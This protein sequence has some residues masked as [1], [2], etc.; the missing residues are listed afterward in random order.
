MQIRVFVLI[1]AAGAAAMGAASG[2]P[3]PGFVTVIGRAVPGF[4]HSDHG[5][6]AQ[7]QALALK[8]SEA[9]LGYC[10][11]PREAAI[12]VLLASGREIAGY[13]HAEEKEL[14]YYYRKGVRLFIVG[15]EPD[16]E[17]EAYGKTLQRIA[18]YARSSAPEARLIGG[19]CFTHGPYETLYQKCG[20]RESCHMV[21]FHCYSD[22]PDTGINIGAVGVLREIMKKYGDA[23]KLVFLGEGWGP[24][25]ELRTVPRVSPYIPPSVSEITLMRQFL[26]NGWNNICTPRENYNPNWVYGVLFFTLSDNWGFDYSHFYNGGL[27][28]FWGNPKDDLLLLFPGDRLTVSNS[29]FEYAEPGEPRG[30]GPWWQM[31]PDTP[32]SCYGIDASIRRAGLRS[33]RLSLVDDVNEVY[34]TQNTARGSVKPGET[35]TFAAWV[36][37]QDVVTDELQ[38]A[39]VRI[40]FLDADG[41]VVGSGAWSEGLDSTRDWTQL[42]ATATAPA[43][44]NRMRIECNLRGVSGTAWFDDCS[45][46]VGAAV[47]KGAV[48]G[49]VL[50]PDNTPIAGAAVVTAP[51]GRTAKTDETGR[52]EIADLDPG[53]YNLTASAEGFSKKSVTK[54]VVA[55]GRTSVA[56][57][58]LEPTVPGAPVNVEVESCGVSGVLKI[59]W[60]P[61]DTGVD[62]FKIYRSTSATSL[63]ECVADNVT[64]SPFYDEHLQD[65]QTYYYT[66]RAVKSGA[67]SQNTDRHPGVP[68]GGATLPIY[69]TNAEPDWANN[70]QTHGQT[71]T[72]PKSGSIVSATC[73]LAN[74]EP[75]NYRSVEFSILEGGPNGKQVGPSKTVTC[76]FNEIG[77]AQW[78]AGEVPVVA[79]KTYYLRLVLDKASAIYRTKADAVPRGRYYMNEQPYPSESDLWSTISLAESRPLD[80]LNVR[81]KQVG[82]SEVEITWHTTAPATS[83]VLYG[84]SAT[85]G[86]SVAADDRMTAE[87]KVLLANLN[88]GNYH[89]C[90]KSARPGL[91][92]AVSL[93][94]QFVVK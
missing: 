59:S 27:I 2:T 5:A 68:T 14:D 61:P 25:R 71:F 51:A 13:V 41:N 52:F 22:E 39:R 82:P 72:V 74:S 40:R 44:A 56:G 3:K 91:P 38:G 86:S 8:H 81:A 24:K 93:D 17:P 58:Q 94:Y 35:Y 69:D 4:G 1:L 75:P 63:G 29:G 32:L 34:I 9:Q 67:E 15:N 77:T 33:Q 16:G 57:L 62:Y 19:N 23:D 47:G 6:P 30:T 42:T 48:E 60:D 12:D 80:I 65:F 87:H 89:F 79:G 49:Y 70:A 21:G 43:S 46:S 11:V 53:V 78:S 66:V 20:F 55:P 90:V 45:V 31:K 85:Y 26:V 28:D 92:D 10:N 64:A 18:A 54:V 84:P 37:T 36:K 88:P 7:V 50:K 83:Q 76:Y 73:V